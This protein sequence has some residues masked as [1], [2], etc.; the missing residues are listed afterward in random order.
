MYKKGVRDYKHEQNINKQV[1]VTAYRWN[2]GA[3]T[4]SPLY[5]LLILVVKKRY[6]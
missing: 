6:F 4:C 2:L 3:G 5:V 1:I